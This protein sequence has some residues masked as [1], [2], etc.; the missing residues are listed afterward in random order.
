MPY[1]VQNIFYNFSTMEMDIDKDFRNDNF[2]FKSRLRV[3]ILHFP[4]Q[5]IGF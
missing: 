2:I 5:K 3:G 1:Y 4:Y